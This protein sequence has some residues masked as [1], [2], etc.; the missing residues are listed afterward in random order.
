[1]SS[2]GD[3]P[4]E[5]LPLI[6]THLLRPQDLVECCLVNSLFYY[7][8]TPLLYEWIYVYPWRKGGKEKVSGI[9][10]QGQLGVV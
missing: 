8:S 10:T 9:H 4:V 6:L 7:F 3:L 1:M 5:L 2:A